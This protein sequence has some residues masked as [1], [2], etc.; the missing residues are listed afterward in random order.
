MFVLIV[1]LQFAFNNELTLRQYELQTNKV[2]ASFRVALITDLHCSEYGEGQKE[3]LDALSS[4]APDIVLFGGDIADD[5]LPLDHMIELVA[6]VAKNTIAIMFSAIMKTEEE[7][8][9]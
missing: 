2:E 6:A 1:A 8:S 9:R 3:L 4:A 7:T 5:D